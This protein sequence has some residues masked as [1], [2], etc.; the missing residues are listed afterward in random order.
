MSPRRPYGQFDRERRPGKPRLLLAVLASPPLTTSGAVTRRRVELAAQLI[1]CDAVTFSNLIS[2]PT[3]DVL[4]IA[5]VGRDPIGW[6]DA[7]AEIAAGLEEADSV[8]FGWGCAEP[9]GP[10]R[11]RH[12]AQVR[13][14]HAGVHRRNLRWW[15]VGGAPRHPSRWQRYTAR[16]Y[17]K[18]PFH[19][20]LSRSLR[21]NI[22]LAPNVRTNSCRCSA[23]WSPH[24]EDL[25]NSD[26]VACPS[27]SS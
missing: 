26:D 6:S 8:L 22:P 27:G 14:L 25:D 15:T 17:P 11:N 7:Q 20:A 12:R 16:E 5:A 19:V 13:W 21:A 1:G 24:E 9:S 23:V 2:I 18:V 4:D 3:A 10:A